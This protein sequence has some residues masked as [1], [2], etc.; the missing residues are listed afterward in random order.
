MKNQTTEQIGEAIRARRKQLGVTQKDLA[1][2]CGTGMRFIVD[3]ERGKPTCHM[4][5]TLQVIRALGLD[6]SLDVVGSN[7]SNRSGHTS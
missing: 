5:K 2:S 3:L 7:Q 4:G 6:L 1:M